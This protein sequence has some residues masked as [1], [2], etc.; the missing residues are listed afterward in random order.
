MSRTTK[1][2]C[3]YRLTGTRALLIAACL[4][5]GL[6]DRIW[7]G[8]TQSL[9]LD[10]CISTALERNHSFPASRSAIAAAEA[11]HRQA[12]SGYWP[13]LSLKSGYL[14]MDQAPNFIFPGSNLHIPQQSLSIPGGDALVTVP[15]GT[16]G[17][18]FPPTDLTLPVSYPGQ[19]LNVPAQ[20]FPIP[21]QDIKLMDEDSLFAVV[22][23]QWLL[24]DGGMRKGIRQQ[25][26]AGLDAAHEELRRTELEITDSVTRLYF[27]AV[28]ARQIRR[29]G[30]DTLARMEATLSLTETMYKEGAGTVNKT[31]YLDNK[32]MVETL[33]SAVALLEKNE[34]LAQAALAYTMGLDWNDSVIPADDEIPFEPVHAD[35]ESFVD[36][37]FA[38]SPDWRRLEA[39]VRAAEG[40]L[41]EAKSGHYPKLAATGELHQWWNSYDAGMATDVN[42]QGWT[43]GVGVK[44]PIFNGFLTRNRVIEARARLESISEQRL[45][46]R[47]GIGLQVRD[48]LLGLEASERRYQATLEAMKSATENRELNSR[49][50]QNDLVETEDVIKAQLMEAFMS[51]Q[52]YKMRYDHVELQSKLNLV[53]GTEVGLRLSEKE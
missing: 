39:G 18:G 37:A 53:V 10:R 29:V 16:L 4:S 8:E 42:K 9:S 21:E 6:A 3:S 11:Q 23:M 34:A 51:A 19:T 24:W 48:T 1:R 28:M 44:V 50:Y 25:A 30:Q 46:L 26:L 49:A 35:L 12:M 20:Q 43:V 27:G 31:D 2:P 47:E 22:D 17:P 52:H 5:A 15:A 32:V 14:R 33:R 13:Q 41:R 36:Q 38:F 40:A 7:A 45:L